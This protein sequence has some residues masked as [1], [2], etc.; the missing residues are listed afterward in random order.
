MM[1]GPLQVS[2][3]RLVHVVGGLRTT[4]GSCGQWF[5]AGLRTTTGSCGQWTVAGLRTVTGSCGGWS[6]EPQVSE[7]RLV[8]VDSGLLQVSEQ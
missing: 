3:Q 6:V 8:H 2:E 1:G 4:T 7:Q 5:V